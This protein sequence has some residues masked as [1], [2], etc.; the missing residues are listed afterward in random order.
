MT[1]D[2]IVF[3]ALKEV[4]ITENPPNS[5]K[6]KYNTWFYGREVSGS[7]Y[8]WCAVFISWLFRSAPNLLK[9]SASCTTIWNDCKAKGM[10]VSAPRKGDIVFFNFSNPK[11]TTK[12]EHIGI[13]VD[14]QADKVIT[15]EGNTSFDN[16][17]SQD[18]GGAVAK[19]T[20]T[21]SMVGFARPKYSGATNTP[22]PTRSIDIVAREVIDGQWGI[23]ND[24]RQR[25]TA[26]GYDYATVQ[27]KVNEIIRGY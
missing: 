26:A 3:L 6:V 16:R 11:S 1:V 2:E 15:V 8:P 18:N 7:A 27:K 14:V 19:R 4:G 21:K 9:K 22:N 10:T 17:G 20:R 25:L 5:N 24:R 23:G 12:A 13:V